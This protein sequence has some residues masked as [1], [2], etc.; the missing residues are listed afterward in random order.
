MTNNLRVFFAAFFL[1]MP[2]W[3]GTGLFAKETKDFLAWNFIA[4]NPEFATAQA[5]QENLEQRVIQQLPFQKNNAPVLE[6]QSRAALSA[7]VNT[8]GNVQVLYEKEDGVVPI[9]SLTKLMTAL[10]V[11]E[12]YN[13]K[14]PITIT[15]QAVA[16]EENF[17]QL[18][19]GDVLLVQDL[20][21][22]LLMESSNDA[23]RA[24]ALEIGRGA[25]IDLMNLQAQ[26]IGLTN[27]FFADEAGLDPDYAGQEITT[28]TAYDVMLLANY[29]I[30]EYPQ[31]LEILSLQKLDLYTPDGKFHHTMNNTNELL[32]YAFWPTKVIGGKTG[33]TPKA[34]GNLLLLLQSPKGKGYL[35]HVVLGAQDRFEEMKNMVSWTYQAHTW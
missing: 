7:F 27:T 24:L 33:W 9:A 5:L 19:A 22:P 2:F 28:S 11:V 17:G 35:V 26:R 10:V 3:W 1:S 12:H 21:Y 30:Q 20:L 23:A 8:Q 16:A 32:S 18:T 34:R 25:F 13:L 31:I 4:Q 14:E 15:K 29:I 6:V